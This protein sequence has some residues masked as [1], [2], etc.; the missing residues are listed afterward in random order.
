MYMIALGIN[1]LFMLPS[2]AADV[3]CIASS[4]DALS[5]KKE[6]VRIAYFDSEDPEAFNNCHVKACK[7]FEDQNID[8]RGLTCFLR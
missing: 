1:F 2:H 3:E 8:N 7:E 5:G 6:E 4:I